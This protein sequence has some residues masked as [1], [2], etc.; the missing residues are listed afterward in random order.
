MIPSIFIVVGLTYMVDNKH[1]LT[2]VSSEEEQDI[3]QKT[4]KK[5]PNKIMHLARRSEYVA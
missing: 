1:E 3:V 4:D 5:T 2:Y